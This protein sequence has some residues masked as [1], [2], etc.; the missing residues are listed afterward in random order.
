[1]LA[2]QPTETRLVIPPSAAFDNAAPF[3]PFV[4][5]SVRFADLPAQAPDLADIDLVI[6]PLIGAG[7]DAVEL[8]QDLG[9]AR[10]R[11]RLRVM[12]KPLPDRAMVLRELRVVANST[13]IVFDL[14]ESQSAAG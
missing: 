13:G 14:P 8:I 11:G 6:A 10:F 9:G 3:S 4:A 1:M 7:F 2:L 5:K 12:S